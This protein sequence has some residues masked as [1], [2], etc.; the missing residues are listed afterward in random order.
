MLSKMLNVQNWQVQRDRE[1]SSRC[2]GLREGGQG[3]TAHAYRVSS[4]SSENT[5]ELVGMVV[6]PCEYFKTTELYTLHSEF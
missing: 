3:M 6:Q 4:W 2:Q 1:W 5:L